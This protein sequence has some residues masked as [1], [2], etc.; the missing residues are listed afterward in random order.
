MKLLGRLPS[1]FCQT[2]DQVIKLA[3]IGNSRAGKTTLVK[4][5]REEVTASRETFFSYLLGVKSS[6]TVG[7]VEEC[8][9][10]IVTHEFESKRLGHVLI[11]DFGHPK[12]QCNT[13]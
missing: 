10:G 7:E 1:Y 3:V 9:A 13:R 4:S 8:T 6:E 11:F 12:Q 2:V 5:M